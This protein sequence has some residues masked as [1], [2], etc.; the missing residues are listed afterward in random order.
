MRKNGIDWIWPA[1][2]DLATAKKTAHQGFFAAS[3]IAVFTVGMI[4]LRKYSMLALVDAVLFALIALGI[5]KTY[6]IASISGLTLYLIERADAWATNG[7][8]NNGAR[9][10][11]VIVITL[12]FVNSIRGTFA[13]HKL[14]KSN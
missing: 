10:V 3:A 2:T 4:L 6:R 12:A 8:P 1:I 13:Y 14:G 7:F 11:F 5:Y 9:I